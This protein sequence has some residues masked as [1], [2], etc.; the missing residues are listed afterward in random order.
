MTPSQHLTAAGVLAILIGIG[1]ASGYHTAQNASASDGDAR[2]DT[3]RKALK[4]S[5]HNL[6]STRSEVIRQQHADSI[7]WV[8]Y[9]SQ[10]RAE[11]HDSLQ[12][13]LRRLSVRRGTEVSQRIP[14][15]ALRTPF[16]GD[17]P[18]NRDSACTVDL[19]CSYAANLLA[20][21]SLQAT[22][23]DSLTGASAVA[24]AACSTAVL[25]ERVRGDSLATLPPRRA[26]LTEMALPTVLG[27]AAMAIIMAIAGAL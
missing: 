17:I 24:V 12:A 1:F 13:A 23:I 14:D 22:R 8:A 26:S 27:A 5:Q 21:D 19:P 25:G 7:H 2:L 9:V 6:D 11:G 10:V 20:S 16:P 15:S 3:A 18:S 4:D